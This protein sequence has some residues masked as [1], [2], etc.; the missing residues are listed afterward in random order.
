MEK[1]VLE[2]ELS[3]E[4]ME[5]FDGFVEHG[6]IDREKYL[7]RLVMKQVERHTA[8]MNSAKAGLAKRKS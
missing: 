4:E 5:A 6:C 7:K 8:R 2:I 1:L 3:K